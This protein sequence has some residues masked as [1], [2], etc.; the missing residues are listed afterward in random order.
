MIKALSYQFLFVYNLRKFENTIRTESYRMDIV[1][2]IQSLN[3][4]IRVRMYLENKEVENFMPL[5]MG[6]MKI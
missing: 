3:I 2:V 1:D 4:H 6:F 5:P